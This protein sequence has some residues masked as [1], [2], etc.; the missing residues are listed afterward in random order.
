MAK[1][2]LEPVKGSGSKKFSPQ[3]LCN[4][5]PYINILLVMSPKISSYY[6]LS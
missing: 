2:N 3:E 4:A 6:G 1:K 5:E